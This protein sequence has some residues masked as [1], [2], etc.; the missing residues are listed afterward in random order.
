M[1][2]P[3]ENENSIA[4]RKRKKIPSVVSSKLWQEYSEKKR[5]K[6]EQLENDENERKRRRK[7]KCI[8]KIKNYI[9]M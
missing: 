6:K 2:F 3:S 9:K 1:F 4:K 7:N 5:A 8:T